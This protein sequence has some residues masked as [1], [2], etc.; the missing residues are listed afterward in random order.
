MMLWV[1]VPAPV[2]LRHALDPKT[3]EPIVYGFDQ[4]LYEYAF[5]RVDAGELVAG[6]IWRRD[7]EWLGAYGRLIAAFREAG[8]VVPLEDG[9][10]AK[11]WESLQCAT[12]PARHHADLAAFLYAVAAPSRGLPDSLVRDIAEA[13]TKD[14]FAGEPGGEDADE[15][16]DAYDPFTPPV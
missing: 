4:F 14:V 2:K 1:H 8:D 9:D 3:R 10:H 15:A 7:A 13:A 16:S 6:H 5:S 11:L 12:I